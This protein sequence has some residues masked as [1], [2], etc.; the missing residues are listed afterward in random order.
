MATPCGSPA[1]RIPGIEEPGD[2]GGSQGHIESDT[3][4]RRSSSSSCRAGEDQ[5]VVQLTALS[6]LPHDG[7][8]PASEAALLGRLRRQSVLP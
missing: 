3:T 2:S 4:E 5:G 1:W 6:Q 8:L 7:V